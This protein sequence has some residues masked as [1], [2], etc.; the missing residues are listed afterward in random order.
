VPKDVFARS[1]INSYKTVLEIKELFREQVTLNFFDKCDGK[2]LDVLDL[3]CGQGRDSL[4][5]ARNGHSVVGVDLSTTGVQQMVE[6]AQKEGIEIDNVED[7]HFKDCRGYDQLKY[8]DKKK[9]KSLIAKY[10]K[11]I[12]KDEH[13]TRHI[14]FP[15]CRY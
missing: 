6:I 4:M 13:D 12:K 3:G 1:N 2:S 15:L 8:I 14:T 7:K 10:Y 5:I 11:Q 9:I